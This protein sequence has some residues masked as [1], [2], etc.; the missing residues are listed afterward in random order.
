MNDSTPRKDD[1]QR[2]P[3]GNQLLS[4]IVIVRDLG[5]S[6][7][8]MLQSLAPDYQQDI[9]SESYEVCIVDST[10]SR[11]LCMSDI[12]DIGAGVSCR[13]VSAASLSLAEAINVGVQHARGDQLC[14]LT[15]STCLLTPGVLSASMTVF[16]MFGHPVGMV[17]DFVLK[18]GRIYLQR[19]G[20][21][22]SSEQLLESIDW[23][24]DGYRLYE[25]GGP[26]VAEKRQ[27]SWF[28]RVIENRGL[29]LRKSTFERVGGCGGQ[30]QLPGLG[31]MPLDFVHRAALLE[32][33]D[34][35][36]LIGEGLFCQPDGEITSNTKPLAED[37]K[38]ESGHLRQ[39]Y[40]QLR[41]VEFSMPSE[42]PYFFG[43]MPNI[44]ALMKVNGMP[45]GNVA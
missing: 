15:D 24:R 4:V 13:L 28:D 38:R 37:R 32:D 41:G 27:P 11:R 39:Q 5:P 8:R 33:T 35:V 12:S 26:L 19:V 45:L 3:V 25:I 30:F 21:R 22:T 23:P 43:T 14:L 6:W 7:S 44:H 20:G 31:M 1:N 10:P 9:D 40:R 42:P 2:Q 34:V 29:F 36:Q 17:R 16:R 18:P